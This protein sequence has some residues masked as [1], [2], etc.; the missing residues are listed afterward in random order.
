MVMKK[1]KPLEV[2]DLKIRLR[3]YYGKEIHELSPDEIMTFLTDGLNSDKK[4][5]LILL[6]EGDYYDINAKKSVPQRVM[7]ILASLLVIVLAPIRYV[8]YGEVG[9]S[10]NTK[11]GNF[12]CRITGEK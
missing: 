4:G 5:D 10:R 9:F 12:L 3:N 2:F 1:T 6:E 11:F 7:T 8:L